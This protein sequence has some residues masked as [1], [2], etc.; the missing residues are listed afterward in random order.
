[1]SKNKENYQRLG[2]EHNLKAVGPAKTLIEKAKREVPG[3][4]QGIL[5]NS[6]SKW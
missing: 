6:K 4:V 5:Q 3:G 2:K 1:M